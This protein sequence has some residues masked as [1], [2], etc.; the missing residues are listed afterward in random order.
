M[1]S[2]I[3]AMLLP[4]SSSSTQASAS[5]AGAAAERERKREEQR[6]AEQ[7]LGDGDGHGVLVLVHV[8]DIGDE[9]VQYTGQRRF[10]HKQHA[11]AVAV[12]HLD[13]LV[14]LRRNVPRCQRPP[15]HSRIHADDPRLRCMLRA[16]RCNTVSKPT[17]TQW[18]HDVVEMR[19][20]LKFLRHD[21]DL[22]Y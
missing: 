17:A 5:G 19:L 4:V 12:A 15:K 22:I 11:Q 21:I 6:L 18:H 3:D 9:R 20:I 8:H 1:S 13:R 16:P 7:H 2:A 10:L 14:Q